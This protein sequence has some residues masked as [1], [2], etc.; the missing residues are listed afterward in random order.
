MNYFDEVIPIREKEGLIV[1][2]SLLPE[3]IETPCLEA[4]LI[5]YD[6]TYVQLLLMQ[7]L[8]MLYIEVIGED[9]LYI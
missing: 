5:L 1:P 4:C 8:N 7:I 6:K 9:F 2:R 3:I